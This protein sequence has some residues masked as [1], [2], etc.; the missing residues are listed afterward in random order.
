MAA[1]EHPM[2]PLRYQ[3]DGRR[4]PG[5]RLA[6][7]VVAGAFALVAV[8][9]ASSA[10]SSGFD[11]TTGGEIA[12]VR[13]GGPLDNNQIRQVI[14]PG[15]GLTWVG[16]FSNAH[17]YPS[18]QRFYTI[19]ADTQRGEKAG[20]DVEHVPTS[21]GVEVG[22]EG[23]I[24]FSLNLDHAALKRFD[25]KYGTRKF[26]GLDGGY[27]YAWES[28]AGWSMF[29]DQVVRP[30]ISNDLREQIGNFRCGELVSSCALVQNNG[31]AQANEQRQRGYVS[32]PACAA[33]DRLKAIP[34]N[35]TTYAPGAGFAITPSAPKQ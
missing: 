25:D 5:R 4:G 24:Y 20:I 17:K 27:R 3:P 33:I 26:R 9:V 23:T 35:V 29:V 8:I 34:P 10:A 21:D 15:S 32:C 18:Q 7:G 19:T 16:M 2:I 28:D 13:D 14:D 22:I 31:A 30:V 6:V 1:P 12:V 11:K